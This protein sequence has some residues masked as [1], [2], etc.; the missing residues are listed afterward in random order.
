MHTCAFLVCT[1]LMGFVKDFWNKLGYS[2]TP[3]QT[4]L[5]SY[6]LISGANV[7]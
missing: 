6:L 5:G 4:Q 1:M 7:E 2:G 3:T